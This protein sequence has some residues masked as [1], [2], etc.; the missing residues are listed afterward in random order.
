MIIGL[1]E[2]ISKGGLRYADVI[3]RGTYVG[4]VV[5]ALNSVGVVHRKLGICASVSVMLHVSERAGRLAVWRLNIL[6]DDSVDNTEVHKF[7]R[8]ALLATVQDGLVLLIEVVLKTR[9][10]LCRHNQ[11]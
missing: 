9:Q 2:E 8:C 3:F 10:K 7:E 4:R 11:E 5:D 6:V 1:T